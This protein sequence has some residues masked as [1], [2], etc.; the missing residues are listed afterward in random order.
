METT[1]QRSKWAG[2]FKWAGLLSGPDTPVPLYFR[3]DLPWAQSIL[4]PR[5]SSHETSFLRTDGGN[6]GIWF[7]LRP[8]KR[9]QAA[10][11]LAGGGRSGRS[12]G[13]GRGFDTTP[14]S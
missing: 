4:L 7:V 8:G 11:L 2:H 14:R 13:T 5:E 12:S 10:N 6:A 9:N 3:T 1:R